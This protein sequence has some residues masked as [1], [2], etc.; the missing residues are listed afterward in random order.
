MNLNN[1]IDRDAHYFLL[2]HPLEYLVIPGFGMVWYK[3]DST[4]EKWVECKIVEDRYK[5]SDNNNYKIELK[6]IEEGYGKEIL[7][8][9]DFVSRLNSGY[10]VKKTSQDMCC[11]EEKWIEPLTNNTY[12]H[13]SAYVLKREK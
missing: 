10:I 6:S 7:Y 11:V 2:M 12:L 1:K 4:R 13:H 8:I 5:L 9:E 3:S